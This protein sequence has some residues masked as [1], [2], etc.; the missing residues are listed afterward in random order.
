M[1]KIILAVSALILIGLL[2]AVA[3]RS[4]NNMPEQSLTT[5]PANT[6]TSTAVS[7]S[8]PYQA[9]G[10]LFNDYAINTPNALMLVDSQGQRTGEDPATGMMY[11]EIPNTSYIPQ[12]TSA[13]L[14]FTAPPKGQY[15]VYV[16]GG[17]TGTYHLDYRM[18]DG[19]HPGT[20]YRTT[21]T[22]KKGQMISYAQN[23][24]PNNLASSTLTLEIPTTTQK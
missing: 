14:H 17:Q 8:S 1:N 11:Q 15:T 9:K 22:I 3:Y 12:G 16:L 5:T 19:Q 10:P 13:G 18:S 21:G 4:R 2:G 23:Y 6:A 24:D 20:T 7:S